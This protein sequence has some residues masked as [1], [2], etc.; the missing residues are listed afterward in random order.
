MRS[1]RQM[2][3]VGPEKS[4]ITAGRFDRWRCGQAALT[5]KI[6]FVGLAG[7]MWLQK[8]VQPACAPIRTRTSGASRPA[9]TC[10]AAA[11]PRTCHLSLLVAA[12]PV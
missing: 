8:S 1:A 9:G 3:G 5:G 11:W 10:L 7:A 2:P 12:E 4:K 6:A